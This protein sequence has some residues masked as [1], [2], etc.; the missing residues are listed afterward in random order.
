M[1]K[2]ISVNLE[3]NIT[4]CMEKVNNLTRNG[5]A[6]NFP[7]RVGAIREALP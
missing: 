2:C 3:N 6:F 5:G 7:A 1:E 4:L